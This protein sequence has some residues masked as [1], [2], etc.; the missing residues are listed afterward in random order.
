[1][2]KTFVPFVPAG[3][4]IVLEIDNDGVVEIAAMGY[5]GKS[6]LTATRPLEEALGLP[7]GKRHL[8]PEMNRREVQ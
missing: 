5:T 3:A 1:M 2:S 8:K 6:C 7:A 4:H